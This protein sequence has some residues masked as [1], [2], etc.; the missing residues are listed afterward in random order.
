MLCYSEPG[1]T[2]KLGRVE[3]YVSEVTIDGKTSSP[4][5]PVKNK[6]AING[7]VFKYRPSE[8]KEGE[9]VNAC[10][11]C[12]EETETEDDFL[13]NPCKCTGSCGAVH[14][15]CL[16]QWIS[17]KVKKEVVGGTLHYNF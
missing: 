15:N 11:I 7:N 12:L 14:L 10:K 4:S 3:F 17:I 2:I 8:K 16:L 9:E 1:Q 6:L 5:G 13:F